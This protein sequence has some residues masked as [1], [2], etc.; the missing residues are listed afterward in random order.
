[1]CASD[2]PAVGSSD[3]LDRLGRAGRGV[4]TVGVLERKFHRP[5]I[6]IDSRLLGEL[7][8]ESVCTFQRRGE[9][10][11][12]KE[13]EQSVAWSAVARAHQRRMTVIAPMLNTETEG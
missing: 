2:R 13:Q 6:W 11:H 9:V 12:A 7:P 4:G 5:G 3:W 8:G 10:A 1:M